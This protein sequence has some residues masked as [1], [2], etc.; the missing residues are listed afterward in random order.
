MFMK[1]T[2]LT[3]MSSR[4]SSWERMN[5]IKIALANPA[6]VLEWISRC[7]SA[8]L[9]ECDVFDLLEFSMQ[10]SYCHVLTVVQYFP[11]TVAA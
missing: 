10:L 4:N 5:G 1:T 3:V 6:T 11:P 8:S 7:H 2:W 9:G